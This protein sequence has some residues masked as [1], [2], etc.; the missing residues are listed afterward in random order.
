ML[1]SN[2]Q[3]YNKFVFIII[4][5]ILDLANIQYPCNVHQTATFHPLVVH[6]RGYSTQNVVTQI[7][8]IQ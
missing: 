6:E 8:N 5:G 2:Q 4:D 7:L 1:G 3:K